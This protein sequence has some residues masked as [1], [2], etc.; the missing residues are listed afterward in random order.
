MKKFLVLTL[1]LPLL[2]VSAAGIA[3]KVVELKNEALYWPGQQLK[4][5]N[6]KVDKLGYYEVGKDPAE[7]LND[8][9]FDYPNSVKTYF[10]GNQ[11]KRITALVD[12]GAEYIVDKVVL[13][14]GSAGQYGN[15]IEKIEVSG[16]E[17][18]NGK[19]VFD[20]PETLKLTAMPGGK[21]DLRRLVIPMKNRKYRYIRVV[22]SSHKS[23]MMVLAELEIHGVVSTGESAG[24]AFPKECW[25]YELENLP[26]TYKLT[27]G[28]L[29]GGGG[30]FI[31]AEHRE[32][33]LL[34][35][36]G[37]KKLYLWIRHAN[38]GSNPTAFSVNGVEK[39]LPFTGG[40]WLWH[41]A[42]EVSGS[43]VE[44]ILQRAKSGNGVV[45]SL[46]LT[47]DPEY[48]PGKAASLMELKAFPE[49]KGKVPFAKQLLLD[50]PDI[51]PV[52]FGKAV[53][54][55]H[56]IKY[57]P[58]A[59]VT[60]E[61]NNIL[62]NGTP[63]F[64]I[65]F[66][67]VKPSD[68][69]LENA[70]VNTFITGMDSGKRP[71]GENFAVV[72]SHLAHLREYD[73]IVRKLKNRDQ[74]QL[75]LHYLCDEPDGNIG[76]TLRDIQLLNEV[77]KAVCPGS[78]TFLNFAANSTMHQAFKVTDIL[79]VDHY[80]IPA[81]RI[82]DIGYSMD[83]M[84]YFSGNRP[85]IFVPQAFSWGGYGQKDGRYPTPDELRA[86]TLLGIIHGAKGVL[87]YEFPAP[88]MSSK[89]ALPEKNPS[90][91]ADL[92]EFI[93]LLNML[94]PGL[95]G[96]DW[97]LPGK[98]VAPDSMRRPEFRLIADKS[99]KQ[100]WLIAVN[101]WDT[102]V[103]CRIDWQLPQ[104]DLTPVELRNAAVS[105]GRFDLLPFGTGVW[106]FET[107]APE[108]LLTRSSEELLA[109]LKESFEKSAAALK[110]ALY[111]GKK[112][113][114]RE[115]WQS[116]NRPENAGICS[117]AEGIHIR[118]VLRFPV[119]L[120]AKCRTRD[121]SVW[122]DPGIEVFLGT[123]GQSRYIHLMVNTLNIQ[124]D[125][126]FDASL[127]APLDKS[128]NFQ[129]HSK[130]DVAGEKAE[131]QIDIPWQTVRKMLG[132]G[133]GDTIIF[134]LA[135]SS[136]QLDWAG[137]TGSGYHAPRRFGVVKLVKP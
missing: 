42:G 110:I 128:V 69:R 78:A 112:V 73:E 44:I 135:S 105:G 23:A 56:G 94:T 120:Q 79:G 107:S 7:R 88:H 49:I 12:L 137:L 119:G 40:K 127:P 17:K 89:T 95:L 101:P 32:T 83:S 131:F 57:R 45:D 85:V 8:G 91:W 13:F 115:S 70:A 16:G 39:V 59:A 18:I 35:D 71:N 50:R 97:R 123:P 61:N 104:V 126:R 92:K 109:E 19:D 81:G 114:L 130:V 46:L 66:Y 98:V 26:G 136:A 36:C 90:L 54:L 87:F 125:W 116:L 2:N 65:G 76:V 129:W 27:S 28:T 102:K 67:H 124:A 25:R 82:V 93:A 20:V 31:T 111:P 100:A 80:P 113:D 108:K 38:N 72:L 11:P 134:N 41:R 96:P 58:P 47:A 121:G 3:Y 62:W 117:D 75:L 60:D 77:V 63:F 118:A 15:L 133:Q 24:T 132:A 51:D 33:L 4:D 68:P 30:S 84:R 53:A 37:G 103:S 1:L 10:W 9:K 21:G 22:C 122:L 48:D 34:P 14:H 86:M 55:H 74:Q 99:A 6:T 64:P 5:T 106:K 43:E 52:E 29:L